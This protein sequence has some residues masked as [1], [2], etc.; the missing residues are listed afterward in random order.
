MLISFPHS[1]PPFLFP[2]SSLLS[3]HS[4]LSCSLDLSEGDVFI[5]SRV[6]LQCGRVS[7]SRARPRLVFVCVCAYVCVQRG[8]LRECVYAYIRED[9]VHKRT[10]V[11]CLKEDL[12]VYVCVCVCMCMAHQ[13]KSLVELSE[14]I[15]VGSPHTHT[16]CPAHLLSPSLS[17]F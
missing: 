10:S 8:C 1:L 13:L 9:Y 16:P 2:P 11:H 4:P 3:S 17:G 5:S 14:N 6:R 7:L 15:S 12:C